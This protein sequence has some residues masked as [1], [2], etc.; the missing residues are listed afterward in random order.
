MAAAN[1][2]T[3]PPQQTVYAFDFDGTLTTR[4]TLIEFIRYARGT[5]ALTAGVMRYSPLLVLM[6][7]RLYPNWKIKQ[8]IF[9]HFFGGMAAAEFDA[10]CARFAADNTQLLRP[11][12][13]EELHRARRRGGQVVIVSASIDNWVRPFFP[14]IHVL[15]TQIETEGGCLTGRFRSANC[16]GKEKVGRL[17]AAYPDRRSY[18]LIAYGDSRGDSELLAAADEAHYKPFRK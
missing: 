8:R 12:G 14:G 10:L 6:K 5:A 7:L 17:L 16:Y 3:R 2:G 13:V 15:G 11:A 18:R 4:D 9:A 1:N